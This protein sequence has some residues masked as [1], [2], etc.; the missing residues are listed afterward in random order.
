MWNENELNLFL[1]NMRLSSS[2]V[3]IKTDYLLNLNVFRN[4]EL[5]SISERINF[6]NERLSLRLFGDDRITD[7]SSRQI[8][9][10]SSSNTLLSLSLIAT[11]IIPRKVIP[12]NNRQYKKS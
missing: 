12:P 11:I 8:T 1:P 9:I 5:H 7:V 4:N 3:I 2:S 10:L 6:K